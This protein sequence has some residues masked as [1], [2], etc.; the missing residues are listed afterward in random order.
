MAGSRPKN[1][2]AQGTHIMAMITVAIPTAGGETIGVLAERI[3][4]HLAIHPALV[5]G[6]GGAT[7]YDESAME[8]THTL[9]GA[10]VCQISDPLTVRLGAVRGFARWLESVCSLAELGHDAIPKRLPKKVRMQIRRFVDA[11][12]NWRLPGCSDARMTTAAAP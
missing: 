1:V 9:S 8:L 6:C 10:M 2:I 4:A 7:E 3:T 5:I 11:P 12:N